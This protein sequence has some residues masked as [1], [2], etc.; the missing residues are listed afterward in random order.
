[1]SC[2]IQVTLQLAST[3][4]YQFCTDCKKISVYQYDP[5]LVFYNVLGYTSLIVSDQAIVKFEI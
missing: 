4:F 2:G 5:P 3:M 1:M